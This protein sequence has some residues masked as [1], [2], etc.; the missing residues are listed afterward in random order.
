MGWSYVKLVLEFG[1]ICLIGSFVG[2]EVLQAPPLR[3]VITVLGCELL[4]VS[5]ETLALGMYEIL[6]IEVY[7]NAME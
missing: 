7:A 4:D 1:I 3:F 2:V 6:T 5:N